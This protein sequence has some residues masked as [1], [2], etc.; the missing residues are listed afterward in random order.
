MSSHLSPSVFRGQF[1]GEPNSTQTNSRQNVQK[2]TK[3]S[4]RNTKASPVGGISERSENWVN[5]KSCA[6]V[7]KN[8]GGRKVQ[9]VSGPS[10]HWYTGQDG[11]RVS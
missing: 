6:G 5:P 7:Q 2:N 10:G 9:A 4:K 3:R 8:A 1:G 11:R